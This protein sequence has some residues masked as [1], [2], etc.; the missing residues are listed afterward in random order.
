A[1]KQNRANKL[2]SPRRSKNWYSAQAGCQHMSRKMDKLP[3]SAAFLENN[4]EDV[5][6]YQIRRIIRVMQAYDAPLAE[7]PY[8]E[9]LRLSGLSEQ[10]MKKRTRQFL[11]HLGWSV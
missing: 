2:D 4:S 7:L 9:L 6:N 8:W 3:L 10:R 11:Q 1:I 5:A